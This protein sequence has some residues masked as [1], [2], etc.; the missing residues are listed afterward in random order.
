MI[1]NIKIERGKRWHKKESRLV[2]P[3]SIFSRNPCNR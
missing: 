2:C 1:N 3:Q